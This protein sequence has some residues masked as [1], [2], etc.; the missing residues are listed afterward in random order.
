[1]PNRTAVAIAVASL[2]VAAMPAAADPVLD[3]SLGVSVQHSDNINYSDDDPVSENVLIPHMAFRI[4]QEGSTFSATA[5]GTLEYRDYL[6]GSFADELRSLFAGSAA[7][8]ISPGRLDWWFED[9]LGRQPINALESAGPSNQQQ[10]NVFSTGPTLRAKFSD[11]LD[12]QLD[13][14]YTN[15]HAEETSDFNSNRYSAVGSLLRRLDPA[16]TVSASASASR[17]RYSEDA[18]RPFD[19]DREDAYLGYQR[20]TESLRFEAA[21][22]YSWLDLRDSDSRNGALLRGSLRWDPT[23][24]TSLGAT[25]SREYSD[26]AQDLVFTPGQIGNVGIGSGINGTVVAPQVYVEHRV[27]FDVAHREDRWRVG[28]APF[29]RKLDYVDDP[30]SNQRS[31]GY[32]ADAGWYFRPTLWLAGFV[33][34]E[35]RKYTNLARTDDDLAWGASLNLQRTRH[36]LWTLMAEHQRRDS[37]TPGAGY[38]E[39]SIMLTVTWQR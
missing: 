11:A 21:A 33:G 9:T 25:V 6:G 7:W 20:R 4:A 1:M 15:S 36:W 39:N 32:Y 31:T 18:S 3:Y 34:Q 38:D 8:H 13:L 10:T 24:R 19:Y 27:G 22:G 16:T 35:R 26:A 12:G 2:L 17:V 28:V 30:L 37:T 14:R 5:A 23:T 29:W